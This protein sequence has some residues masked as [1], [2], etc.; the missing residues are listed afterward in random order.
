[1]EYRDQGGNISYAQDNGNGTVT[2]FSYGFKGP[3]TVN[4]TL[5]PGV[6]PQIQNGR[7]LS[8]E[9]CIAGALLLFAV[10]TLDIVLTAMDLVLELGSAG[11][12]TPILV[13]ESLL[14]A[15]GNV[16]AVNFAARACS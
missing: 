13:A 8:V 5:F 7:P 16:A 9:N 15:A 12:F 11:L 1:M 2:V 6:T 3:V 4:G 10:G 14:V